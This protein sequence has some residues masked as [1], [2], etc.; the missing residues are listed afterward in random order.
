M[1]NKQFGSNKVNGVAK[2]AGFKAEFPAPRY[3]QV[4]FEYLDNLLWEA[5]KSLEVLRGEVAE[6]FR[7]LQSD[8]T[9][10]RSVI[11]EIGSGTKSRLRM[12]S[13]ANRRRSKRSV[14]KQNVRCAGGR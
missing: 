3:F 4:H 13:S 12:E 10:D 5:A 1:A 9:E 11:D 14:P 2:L 8:Q 7:L 6:M